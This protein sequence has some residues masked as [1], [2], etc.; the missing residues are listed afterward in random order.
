MNPSARSLVTFLIVAFVFWLIW[1]RL[2]VVVLVQ[3]P[4]WGLLI[5][6]LVLFLVLDWVVAKVLRKP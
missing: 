3:I 2:H 4:W 6:G 5:L 1:S